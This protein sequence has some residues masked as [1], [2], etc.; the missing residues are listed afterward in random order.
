MFCSFVLANVEAKE[1]DFSMMLYTSV[2]AQDKLLKELTEQFETE[3]GIKVNYEFINWAQAREKLTMWSLGGEA[4]DVAD[5]FWSYT[6]SDLGGGKYGPMPIEALVGEYIPD[7]EERWNPKS[8]VDVKYKGHLFGVPWRIDL[9]PTVFRKDFVEEAGLDPNSLDTWDDLVVW[10]QK[11]TQKDAQGKVVRW[12]VSAVGQYDQFF[13][14]FIWQAGGDV[15]NKETWEVTLYSEEGKE[16]LQFLTDLVHKYNIFP[17][18]YVL[19]PSYNG[20]AEF[21]AGH[22]AVIPSS[23]ADVRDLVERNAPFLAD[24]I[25]TQKPLN[26]KSR[27]AFQGAG[28][29]GVLHGAKDV[30][31]AMRWLAFL[32][33][34]EVQLELSRVCG[35]MTPCLPA[36]EDPYFAEHWWYSGMIECIPY[37]RTTQYP[38]PGWGAVTNPK[39]GAPLYDM[40]VNALGGKMSVDEALQRAHKQIEELLAGF[41][42]EK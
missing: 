28:Y 8:L 21:I 1:I 37:G 22:V 40:M 2:D 15:V 25:E 33:R 3:T 18:D 13:F 20:A 36:L 26:N 11:L 31:A 7:L 32:A 6:F 16:A 42:K 34:T 29:F 4:P 12:G 9:R 27:V 39:P 17:A 10:G 41:E 5:M 23:P 19:D 35:Q 24:K 38:H 30:D 14:P